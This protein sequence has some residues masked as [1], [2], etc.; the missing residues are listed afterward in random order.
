ME[1][2]HNEKYTLDD[3]QGDIIHLSHL[4]DETMTK[5]LEIDHR[6]LEAE[7]KHYVDRASAFVWVAR[8]LAER[9][10]GGFSDARRAEHCSNKEKAH[11]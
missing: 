3:I 11:A 8:D 7:A 4:I 5:L 10:Q 9:I 2:T 6:A 1:L